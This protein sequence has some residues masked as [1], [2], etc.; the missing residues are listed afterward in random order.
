MA[1]TFWSTL[2]YS[3]VGCGGAVLTIGFLLFK[4]KTFILVRD[5]CVHIVQRVFTY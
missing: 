3:G 2:F 5:T 1:F 4:I